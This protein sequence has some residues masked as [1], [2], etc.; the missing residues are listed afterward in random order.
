MS[1]FTLRALR[2]NGDFTSKLI[3][4]NRRRIHTSGWNFLEH[5]IKN[6]SDQDISETIFHE[7]EVSNDGEDDILKRRNKSG[8]AP[9]HQNIVHGKPPFKEPLI[10]YHDTLKYRRRE[11]GR[12]GMSSGVD[13][14]ILWPTKDELKEKLEYEKVTHPDSFQVMVARAK[15]KA[16]E[17]QEATKRRDEEIRSKAAKLEQW[18]HELQ[19]RTHKKLMEAQAAKEK[20]ERLLEEVR[21][22]FGF[23]VDPRD[24]RFKELLEKKEKEESKRIKAE[25]KKMKQAKML[26]KLAGA[27][28]P[29]ME[30]PP[31][32]DIVN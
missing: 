25:K 11:F 21:Q 5:E 6:A 22:H 20:K 29:V 28:K 4:L 24:Q 27:A 18:K 13:P 32:S 23:K 19:Q 31:S 7:A 12:Y 30:S 9:Q 14:G 26:E 1:G 17:E 10:P 3:S 16:A 15:L 2:V 8:L